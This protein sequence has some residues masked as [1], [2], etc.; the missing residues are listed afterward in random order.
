MNEDLDMWDADDFEDI[1]EQIIISKVKD[2]RKQ[3][4]IQKDAMDDEEE[5]LSDYDDELGNLDNLDGLDDL[6]NL[7]NLD[8]S[9][10]K[11]NAEGDNALSPNTDEPEAYKTQSRLDNLKIN[12]SFT[13]G[14]LRAFHM[15]QVQNFGAPKVSFEWGENKQII[16]ADM[17]SPRLYHAI[18][19]RIKT[20]KLTTQQKQLCHTI[21]ALAYRTGMRINELAGIKLADI[22]HYTHPNILL[23]PNAYRRLKSSSAKRRQLI[24]YLL[25]P[26]E[27]DDFKNLYM[28]QRNLGTRYLFAQGDGKQPLPTYF[29]SNLMRVLWDA[30]LG[31]D[32]HS[33]TFHSLR[34]T[35]ISQL[36][37]VINETPLAQVMTDYSVIE[38][39]QITDALAGNHQK[40]GA[41]FA[42][43]SHV[44][45]LTCDTTFEHYIH[46]AHLLAGWQLSQASLKLPISILVNITTNKNIKV[47]DY[48]KV[49]HQDKTA[50]SAESKE[51][52]LKKLRRHFVKNLNVYD[53]P[54]FTASENNEHQH[55]SKQ[56]SSV[57]DDA[58]PSIFIEA[59]Y[60]SVIA[61]LNEMKGLKVAQ[62]ESQIENLAIKYDI[63]ISDAH[64]IYQRA[65]HLNDN[66]LMV[67]ARGQSAQTLSSLALDNTYQMSI[68]DPE[69]LRQFVNIY[70]AKHIK[71]RSYLKFGIK[72]S[73]HKLLA[74]FM[75]IGCQIIEPHHWQILSNS[76]QA[77][78]E[79]K[80]QHELEDRIMTAARNDCEGFEV[81]V[82]KKVGSNLADKSGYESSGV[83]K[84]I[85]SLLVVLVGFEDRDV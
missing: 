38:C 84:F 35:A 63:H 30:L 52:E 36:A 14:R 75:K 2:G 11:V 16:K 69:A 27:L 24:Q 42:L 19:D 57:H 3:D 17:V 76:K 72:K 8:N 73:Q 21:L 43:A 9:D 23:A 45:H 37:L 18:Q 59:R 48:Q 67:T 81:R 10:A 28:H 20:S 66:K 64:K 13:Y 68:N 83:L 5:D 12:Q 51:V 40:Q 25:K 55:I 77:V 53:V 74:E 78:R 1:Y 41:W 7:D 82:V 54:L 58:K 6:D 39:Q 80:N 34:H 29:F 47:I 31:K 15:Y 56:L 60:H 62:R 49:Y 44:G 65:Y 4:V 79:F 32:N 71:T 70:Q 26:H 50:Y 22:E 85:G 46:I 33:F 61:F